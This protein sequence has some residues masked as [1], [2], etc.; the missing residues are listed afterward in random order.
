MTSAYF[1]NWSIYKTPPPKI[2][3]NV[4]TI[5][6]AFLIPKP[7]GAVELLDSWADLEKPIDDSNGVVAAKGLINYFQQLKRLNPLLKLC[8]AVGGWG[9]N[10][11]TTMGLH[12]P[13]FV[14]NCV[15]MV[16]KYGFDGLDI[17]WEYPTPPEMPLFLEL[18]KQLRARMAPDWAL[19]IAAPA[20][21]QRLHYN[22][23]EIDK[24]I[25]HWNLMTYDFSGSWSPA[26]GYHSNL[27]GSLSVDSTVKW[28]LQLGANKNKII[29]GIPLYGRRFKGGGGIGD[30]FTSEEAIDYK[31]LDLTKCKYDSVNGS[32]YIQNPGEIIV[33]DSIESIK[34]KKKYV[35]NNRLGGMFVWE[36]GG[37]NGM[38]QEMNR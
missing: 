31:E 9:V 28:Y 5:Y 18:L 12:L 25:T 3:P 21:D 27:Y 29:M 10:F 24:L 13:V 22:V 1:A 36:M 15:D 11:S 30:K 35:R 20:G 34:D 8:F 4:N 33:F 14:Q 2:N 26:I 19:S 6:Y 17:D 32:A 16:D 7:N 23:P 38:I 37:D